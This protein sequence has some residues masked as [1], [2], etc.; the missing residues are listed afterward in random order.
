MSIDYLP[1]RVCD[2]IVRLGQSQTDQV[3]VLSASTEDKKVRNSR[4]AW[5]DDK[6]IDDWITPLVYELNLQSNWNFDL[7]Y[8]EKIQFTKYSEGQFYNWHVDT[9][10]NPPE[11]DIQRKISVVVPLSK[12]EDYEGGDLEF[13]DSMIS[14]REDKD[15]VV[16]DARTRQ[17]GTVIA[18]PSYVWHQVTPITKG[19]RLSIVI[20]Y[21]GKKWS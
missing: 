18:F 8:R 7:Q 11:P 13:Y 20:W 14:P 12:S 5:L 4:I 21:N 6:W 9:M 10:S 19:E 3:G 2:D 1:H 17:K 16:R 15:R